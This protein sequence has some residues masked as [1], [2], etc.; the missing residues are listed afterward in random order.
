MEYSTS[1]RNI[2]TLNPYEREMLCGLY[3]RYY[4][5]SNEVLFNA[6]LANKTHVLILYYGEKTVG[7]TTIEVYGRDWNDEPVV[8]VYSGD[9]IVEQQH[10][11]QQALAYRWIR[12]IG[13][14]RQANA[15]CFVYWLL[16]VK[17]HRTYKFLPAFTH[18]FYPHWASEQRDLKSFLDVLAREKFGKYYDPLT[19][20]V[21]FDE[22]RGHLKEAYAAIA[23]NEKTKPA[24]SFFLERNPGYQRGDELACLCRFDDENLRPLTRR[25]LMTATPEKSA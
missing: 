19:G 20:I 11:G 6:D 13:E 5:G 2:G 1:I 9:T 16:I 15:G 24:V 23:D 8:V 4:D 3:L 21:S 25:I 12:F 7:F 14:L 22:S 10:W 18:T 17:G